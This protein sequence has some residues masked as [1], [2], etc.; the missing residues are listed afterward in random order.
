SPI[1]LTVS[2]HNETISGQPIELTLSVASNA[3]ASVRDVLL[4]ARYPF[5]FKF[6]SADPAPS[7]NVSGQSASWEVGDLAPGRKRTITIRGT[8]TGEQG[9]GRVFNFTA[10]TRRDTTSTS[11]AIETPLAN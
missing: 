2:G 7:G 8:L 3:N 10:G 9:D 11:T 5:G 1:S 4:N 6:S